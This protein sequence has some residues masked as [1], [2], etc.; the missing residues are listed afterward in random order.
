MIVILSEA[1][2]DEAVRVTVYHMKGVGLL[3]GRRA[4]MRRMKE[5]RRE[6]SE[7]RERMA[8]LQRIRS[9][10]ESVERFDRGEGWGP[11]GRPSL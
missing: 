11:G 5:L 1:E 3:F 2:V 10:R 9:W 7:L 6:V 4:Q 8:Y